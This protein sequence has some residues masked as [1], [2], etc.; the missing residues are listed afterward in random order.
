MATPNEWS[1]HKVKQVLINPAYAVAI[2]PDLAAANPNLLIGRERW[3]T[4]N[5]KL[6]EELGAEQWLGLLLDVLQGDFVHADTAEG[7]TTDTPS[8]D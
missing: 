2:S 1:E 7:E 3:V 6:I 5:V 4:A 8:Q